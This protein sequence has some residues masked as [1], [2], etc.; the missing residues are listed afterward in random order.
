[1]KFEIIKNGETEVEVKVS[2][3]KRRLASD[4]NVRVDT[5]DV[6]SFLLGEGIRVSSTLKETK[7][8]NYSVKPKLTGVWKFSK[9]FKPPN[10]KEKGEAFAKKHLISS[11]LNNKESE[12]K[13]EQPSTNRRRRRR[14]QSASPAKE[15]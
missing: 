1:M 14:K 15:D 11:D 12:N 3:P 13:D 5:E 7:V 9:Y 4:K 8:E 2:I 6:R 10:L